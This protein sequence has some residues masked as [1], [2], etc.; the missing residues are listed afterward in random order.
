LLTVKGVGIMQSRLVIWKDKESCTK[1]YKNKDYLRS[2]EIDHQVK[3]AMEFGTIARI[4]Q[5]DLEGFK[6]E[7]NVSVY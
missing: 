3:L 7:Y 4:D 1:Y 6:S 5:N 2:E